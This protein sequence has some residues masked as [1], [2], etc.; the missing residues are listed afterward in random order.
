MKS[1]LIPIF[2]LL[3]IASNS[4]KISINSK[5]ISTAEGLPDVL[6]QNID[7]DKEGFIWISSAKYLS[8]FDGVKFKNFSYKSLG[9]SMQNRL[10]FVPDINNNIWYYKRISRKGV[11]LYILDTKT[12]QSVFFDDYFN[13][14]PFKNNEIISFL[15]RDNEHNVFI[16]VKNKGLYKYNGKSFELIL[17]VSNNKFT[18]NSM[19]LGVNN[20][21]A[22]GKKVVMINRE[23][24]GKQV[25]N[26]PRTILYISEFKNKPIFI[27]GS[28]I[29]NKYTIYAI[30]DGKFIEEFSKYKFPKFNL[31]SFNVYQKDNLGNIWLELK[32]KRIYLDNSGAELITDHYN[33]NNNN[34]LTTKKIIL[35]RSYVDSFNNYWIASDEGLFKKSIVN[36]KFNTYLEGKSLRSMFKRDSILYV[37]TP[38]G[39]EKINLN[40]NND[41]PFFPIDSTIN[42]AFFSLYNNGTLWQSDT[43]KIKKYTFKNQKTVYY[44]PFDSLLRNYNCIIRHP[45]T[46]KIIIGSPYSLHYIDEKKNKI[47]LLNTVQKYMSSKTVNIRCFKQEGNNLWIGTTKGIFLMNEDEQIVSWIN[48]KNGLPNESIQ[49]IYIENEH[50]FWLASTKGLIKWD[51]KN[52]K[53][54]SFTEKNGLSNNYVYAVYKDDFGFF[55]L[56]TN[57]GLNRYAPK[58][59]T[60]D[61]FMPSK[62]IP[63]KEFNAY[64]HFQDEDGKLYFGGLNG[65]V[66]F[67]PSDFLEKEE[68]PK[69]KIIINEI[70]VIEEN[71][72]VDK[73]EKLFQ[74]NT[75]VLRDKYNYVELD[76]TLMDFL[77]EKPLQ[78][79]YKI[80]GVNNDYVRIENSKIILSSL[81]KGKYTLRIKGQGSNGL[82]SNLNKP[83]NVIVQKSFFKTNKFFILL[84]LI[85]SI[86]LY[87]PYKRLITTKKELSK[88]KAPQIINKINPVNKVHKQ[89]LEKLDATIIENLSSVNFSV[90]F[91]SHEL[92][93]SERQLQ[94]R[95]KKLTNTTP[96]KYITEIRLL[97]A[98]R[99]IE[100]QEV[101][102]V[103]DLSKKVGFSTTEYFSKLF[104][105]RFNKNPSDL[106][107]F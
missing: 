95:I 73:K 29:T 45:K 78:Y 61:I 40:N 85:I 68:M 33:N 96:N 50:I 93:L 49:D 75:I 30:K 39:V 32:D 88:N 77:S 15:Y 38:I 47:F 36:K 1:I 90:E 84:G 81:P 35:G 69:P 13:D 51:R 53:F 27:T 70:K 89:W 92:N 21:Y 37:N 98:L 48:K 54:I 17:N 56:P 87:F 18:I 28:F 71:K 4:Q 14:A 76:F 65:L 72:L 104:K 60:N 66:I 6:T 63:D 105:K 3:S 83:I 103:K 7:Q 46:K 86:I 20:W 23:S 34:N 42:Y 101:I 24:L 62:G 94:R 80:D 64:S 43:E 16:S 19:Q 41:T 25:F 74:N 26:C 31:P 2:L 12:S 91:L 97:E 55:W 9:I 58:T 67:D 57:N 22:Y 59:G 10:L 52:N 102:T 79:Q 106:L 99:L 44:Q 5:N 100:N 82:W 107:N 11:K 8:R